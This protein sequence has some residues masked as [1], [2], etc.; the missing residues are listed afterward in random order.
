[1]YQEM[2]NP[3][4]CD[5]KLVSALSVFEDPD[6]VTLPPG[7]TSLA[8][9]QAIYR[10]TEQPMMRRLKA[11]IAALPYEHPKLAVTMAGTNNSWAAQLQG[12]IARSAKVLELHAAEPAPRGP[13]DDPAA[14]SAA[15]MRTPMVSYRRR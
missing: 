3:T 15:A 8:F 10:S 9:L 1:M 12:C 13:Y 14:V 4:D 5:Q 2:P 7:A 11:A 6:S